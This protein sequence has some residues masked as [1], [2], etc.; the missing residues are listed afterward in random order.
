MRGNVEEVL[1]DS[2]LLVIGNKAEEFRG[3]ESRLSDGQMVIDL[4]RILQN[5]SG[6]SSY[7]GIC[8]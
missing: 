3:L 7:Q 8:W 5:P 6:V 2:E 1:K 4:V